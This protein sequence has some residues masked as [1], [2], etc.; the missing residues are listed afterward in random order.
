[1]AA[2]S[3]CVVGCGFAPAAATHDGM[4]DA[5]AD[6]TIDG[7]R[8]PCHDQWLDGSIRFNTPTRIVEL[9]SPYSDRDPYV[10]PD[11]L[12]IYFSTNRGDTATGTNDIYT[13]TRPTLA[14][15]FGTPAK[16][17]AESTTASD[18]KMSMTDDG[19]RLVVSN[20]ALVDADLYEASRPVAG[21]FGAP[22]ITHFTNIDDSHDQQDPWI[23]NDGLRIYFAVTTDVQHIAITERTATNQDFQATNVLASLDSGTGDADPALSADERIIVFSSNRPLAGF[24]GANMWYSTRASGS[25]AFAQPNAIPD[26]NTAMNDGDAVLSADQCQLYF[27]SDATGDY[28]IYVAT[29]R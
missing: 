20:N 3:A 24:A 28:D 23:S 18:G 26:L 10:T 12:T 15:P 29:V 25:G 21:S 9:S 22:D 6:V 8:V 16:F 2:I 4:P 11:G 14:M 5:P 13:A 19:L 7:P 27:A 1:V 17:A